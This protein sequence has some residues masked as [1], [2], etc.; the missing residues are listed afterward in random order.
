MCK[1]LKGCIK[2][3]I[4]KREITMTQKQ[5]AAMEQAIDLLINNDTDVSILFR[6]DGLLKEITKRLVERALQ[7]EMNNHLG[8]SKYNQSDAQNSR[9]G[10]NT[11]NLITKN[12]A[13][14]IEVPRDR[15]SS[16]APSLVA[17][18]Q[19]R[20]DGFDDKVLSL[21]AKG[22]SLS[23]IKLQLQELY[24]SYKDRKKLAGDLKPI[25]TVNT[26][27]KMIQ[28]FNKHRLKNDT[29]S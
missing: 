8:Y 12:G 29:V 13:V 9:N 15:N 21:Y 23:D 20:L 3:N 19:R 10:Y 16:F 27:R 4:T 7:S 5:N 6:E 2:E 26:G 17:K 24:V 18:R 11:K 1:F 28:I 25:Y 22:M 14:E